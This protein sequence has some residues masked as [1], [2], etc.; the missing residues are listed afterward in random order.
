MLQLEL[1]A[2]V[3]A[4]GFYEKFGFE[5]FG[6]QYDEAGIEHQSMALVL[7]PPA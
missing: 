4:I 6:E 5:A 2:Q 3:S 1:H 7:P